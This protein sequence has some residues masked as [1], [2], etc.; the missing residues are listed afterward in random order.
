LQH[1][2]LDFSSEPKDTGPV[3]WAMK[4]LL[5]HKNAA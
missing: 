4:R 3:T 5:D 2:D 1:S